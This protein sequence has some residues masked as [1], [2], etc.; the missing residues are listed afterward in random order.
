MKITHSGNLSTFSVISMDIERKFLE[1]HTPLPWIEPSINMIHLDA[2]RSF[3]FGSSLAA[4]G[5]ATYLLEH[6]LRMAVLDPINSGSQRKIPSKKIFDATFG[7]LL[8]EIKYAHNLSIVIPD[9]SD[10]AWWNA[11]RKAVRNKVNHVDV[12][13]IFRIAKELKL[14]DDYAYSGFNGS[15]GWNAEN[16]HSWGMFWHRFGDRLASDFI[17]QT[18]NQVV[19]L[20]KNTNWKSDESWWISQKYEYEGFFQESWDFDSL[21]KSLNRVYSDV[22]NTAHTADDGILTEL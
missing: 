4:I 15:N 21:Q 3:V 18:T 20:I 17:A 9:P 8:S 6:S 19:K 13:A 7:D 11:V 10:L 2:V 22:P 1:V 14:D 12:P 16:P 5:C